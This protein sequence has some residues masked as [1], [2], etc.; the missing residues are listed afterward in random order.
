MYLRILF[1]FLDHDIEAL[2]D[3]F[4]QTANLS[5]L[6]NINTPAADVFEEERGSDEKFVSGENLESGYV[7]GSV[8]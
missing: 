7:E 3:K 8:L 4:K 6:A 1:L 5:N 2:F